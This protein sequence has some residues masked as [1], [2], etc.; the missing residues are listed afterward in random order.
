M[1]K[2]GAF[3][4]QVVTV[5]G[6]SVGLGRQYCLDLAAEGAQVVVVARGQS[7]IDVAD[8][9][10]AAGGV[11]EACVADVRNG[12]EIIDTTVKKFGRIDGLLI[13][14]GILRDR[15][16]AKMTEQ[17]W[18]E[19]LDI[20]LNGT[21][22]CLRAV[23]PVMREQ[24]HGR[25]VLTAT[26]GVVYGNFGQANY[27]AAKGAI[28]SLGATLAIEGAQKN[29]AV[30][31]V[32]PVAMT[33]L[34]AD[35]FTEEMANTLTVEGVSPFVIALLH[36]SCKENGGFFEVGGGWASKFRWQRSAGHRLPKNEWNVSQALAHMD[37]ISRFDE[38]VTYP[39]TPIETLNA[40]MGKTRTA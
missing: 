34:T 39:T 25:I 6:G 26:S 22:A 28:V 35:I 37:D 40:C 20:H 10:R 31:T 13:N 23:W 27:V 32:A 17:D 19:V 33:R 3:A 8:E 24:G 12:Q 29:I 2:T 9:I 1:T 30:N 5:V 15:S 4:G 18:A 7:A 38:R 21:Y 11:A 16:F 36:P 14:A